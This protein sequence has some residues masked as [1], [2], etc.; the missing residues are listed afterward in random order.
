MKVPEKKLILIL[1]IFIYKAFFHSVYKQLIWL[2]RKSG[3]G[4][5]ELGDS[6][7]L[8]MPRH[9][10]ACTVRCYAL[11][12]LT[13]DYPR[14]LILYLVA[15]IQKDLSKLPPRPIISGVSSLFQ[16]LA[17]YVDNFL[18]SSK[19]SFSAPKLLKRH[20]QF[21]NNNWTNW[22]HGTNLLMHL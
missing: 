11:K 3:T 18:V 14:V 20:Q 6:S 1:S 19:N 5:L 2:L 16:P 17:I 22:H 21:L 15:Q 13:N 10:P 4:C 8:R 9:P 7:C 12:A